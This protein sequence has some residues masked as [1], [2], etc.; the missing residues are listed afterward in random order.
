M[1]VLTRA[2]ARLMWFLL[3]TLLPARPG[4]RSHSI[5]SPSRWRMAAYGEQ[6]VRQPDMLISR[7]DGSPDAH[8]CMRVG[9]H[10]HTNRYCERL[11][12]KHSCTLHLLASFQETGWLHF[13]T[14][15][16][17]CRC[18]LESK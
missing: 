5:H 15:F 1:T 17:C 14:Y 8:V 4:T 6:P 9:C 3:T 2:P 18:R 7:G 12:L 11:C 13:Q 16:V 10:D